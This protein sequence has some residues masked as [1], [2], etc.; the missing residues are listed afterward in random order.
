M[1]SNGGEPAF[2]FPINALVAKTTADGWVYVIPSEQ[3]TQ[4]R[5]PELEGSGDFDQALASIKDTGL[6][7]A[8]YVEGIVTMS[9]T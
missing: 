3:L 1:A 9:S 6:D 7:G 4:F 5:R 2:E 8:A